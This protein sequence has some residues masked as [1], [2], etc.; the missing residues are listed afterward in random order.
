VFISAMRGFLAV[1]SPA[2][3]PTAWR[4]S[5]YSPR[6]YW[7]ASSEAASPGATL[8]IRLPYASGGEQSF[9]DTVDS[10]LRVVHA[11]FIE[12]PAAA[13]GTRSAASLYESLQRRLDNLPSTLTSLG[14]SFSAAYVAPDLRKLVLYCSVT[15]RWPIYYRS[16]SRTF[17][18]STSS[19]DAL[20]S[21]PDPADVDFSIL[22]S[23][24]L[25]G[26]VPADRTALRTVH[27]LPPGYRL[28]YCE[29]HVTV[30][31]VD[32]LACAHRTLTISAAANEFRELL[33]ASV[34]RCGQVA[35][36]VVT[37][38]SG[39]VDS[40]AVAWETNTHESA[41]A[42]TLT[43]D[44]IP[45]LAVNYRHAPLVARQARIRHLAFDTSRLID[46]ID[47]Y[48][49]PLADVA[50]LTLRNPNRIEFL[51]A[52]RHIQ[53]E[54]GPSVVLTGLAAEGLFAYDARSVLQSQGLR[55]LNPLENPAFV[56]RQGHLWRMFAPTWMLRGGFRLP[57][58]P[59]PAHWALDRLGQWVAPDAI[60]SAVA[61]DRQEVARCERDL[62][63]TQ[64]LVH[65]ALS[66]F[67]SDDEVSQENANVYA[68]HG[69]VRLDPYVDRALIEFCLSLHPKHR[70]QFVDGYCVDK[71]LL[72][73][74]YWHS[75]SREVAWAT[76]QISEAVVHQRLAALHAWQLR[77]LLNEESLLASAGVLDGAGVRRILDDPTA[78]ASRPH[79]GYLLRAYAAERWLRAIALRPNAVSGVG[80]SGP[81]LPDN[82]SIA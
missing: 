56:F 6:N 60:D 50:T 3:A 7:T 41:L 25:D 52:A 58:A 32:E 14:G 10:S 13:H 38:L 22:P 79:L 77:A 70:V 2:G 17:V 33:A 11:G 65:R 62:P 66:A 53:Q 43:T 42:L 80:L 21:C 36:S 23:M 57:P 40:A 31:R 46:D 68:P 63:P 28:T 71:F 74:G 76:Q 75:L 27:R 47:A 69:S 5:A 51:A 29:G 67:L 15:S 44:E 37:L 9:A 30:E 61:L 4:A 49:A 39:G 64:E 81:A 34:T 26:R 1:D 20:A 18:W 82:T 12:L 78:P 8:E 24:I 59:L 19:A 48:L 72:R 55:S 16:G 45:A 35:P 54:I 73:Y